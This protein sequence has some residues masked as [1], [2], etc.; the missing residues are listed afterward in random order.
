MNPAVSLLAQWLEAIVNGAL[1]LDPVAEAR[2]RQL[3]GKTLAIVSTAPAERLNVRCVGARLLVARGELDK[4]NVI[5]TGTSQA[6][7]S[8]LTG[9]GTPDVTIEGDEVLLEDLRKILRELDPSFVRPLTPL[10]GEDSAAALTGLI[11]A[12]ASAL[13]S[14]VG[15]LDM[16]GTRWM[17]GR[18]AASPDHEQFAADVTGLRLAVDRLD[19]RL[20]ALEMRRRTPEAAPQRS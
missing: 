7:F 9:L 12:G 4:P 20:R 6:L 14:F 2:L 15:A 8:A 18:F 13:R 19:A 1:S 16:R 17:Q 10:M 3:D 11:S 5:V